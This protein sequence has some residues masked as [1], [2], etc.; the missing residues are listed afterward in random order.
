[1]LARAA[2]AAPGSL[3]RRRLL[4]TAIAAAKDGVRYF[5]TVPWRPAPGYVARE[6]NQLGRL[7]SQLAS[8]TELAGGSL[9][10]QI[11]FYRAALRIRPDGDKSRD[12]ARALLA[13]ALRE[14]RNLATARESLRHYLDYLRSARRDAAQ[15]PRVR[16]DL[17][18]YAGDFPELASEVRSIEA[19]EL[20]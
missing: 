12:L 10:Q 3:E 5:G 6:R 1:M 11:D 15:V 17:R 8:A 16:A 19:A 13:L 14:P 18:I 20:P 4:E 7:F 9:E 2:A